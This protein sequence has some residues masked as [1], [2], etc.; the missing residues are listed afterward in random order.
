MIT[1]KHFASS[2]AA[3]WHEL[4]PLSE[5]YIR[6]C[7]AQAPRFSGELLSPL[8]ASQRGLV[9]EV[10]FQ[11]FA[12]A[13]ASDCSAKELSSAD[14]EH[15]VAEAHRHV[16][17]LRRFNRIP[18]REI[19]AAG[20]AEAMLIAERLSAFFGMA[21]AEKPVVLPAFPGCGLL[22]GCRGDVLAGTTLFE[23]K[24]G[25]RSFRSIDIRQLLCYCALNF[26]S[27]VHDIADVCFVNPRSG[28]YFSESLD[29]MCRGLSGRPATS[30]LSDIVAYVSDPP[31][32]YAM[33]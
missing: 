6:D 23:V 24:A 33:G 32:R 20:T 31:D 30:V 10:G 13:S 17:G 25:A 2:Q 27:K 29:A 26:A 3:F 1:E 28:R 21:A 16:A 12:C 14:V 22:D 15:C 11:I 5:V 19:A 18:L 7:N 4:L 9:N 8:P